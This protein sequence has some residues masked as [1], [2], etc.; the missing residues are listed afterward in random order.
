MI[1]KIPCANDSR[2]GEGQ[3]HISVLRQRDMMRIIGT[4]VDQRA[5]AATWP[6]VFQP[7]A[8]HRLLLLRTCLDRL[9]WA[10]ERG[11]GTAKECGEEKDMFFFLS[12]QHAASQKYGSRFLEGSP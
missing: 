9:T 2:E 10:N 6:S 12:A 5:P 3:A 11:D 1:T 8:N 7:S 4:C